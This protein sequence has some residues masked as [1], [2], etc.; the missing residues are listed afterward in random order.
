MMI[1][2][3]SASLFAD[4]IVYLFIKCLIFIQHSKWAASVDVINNHNQTYQCKSSYASD[5]Q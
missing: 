3:A 1:R 5:L 2:P 4:V